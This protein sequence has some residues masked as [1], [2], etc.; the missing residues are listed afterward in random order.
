VAASMREEPWERRGRHGRED[1]RAQGRERRREQLLLLLL[2]LPCTRLRASVARGSPEGGEWQE[3]ERERCS[4]GGRG[5]R[6]WRRRRQARRRS[7][8]W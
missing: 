4:H 1:D 3:V 7:M 8:R 5:W 2:P 6:G